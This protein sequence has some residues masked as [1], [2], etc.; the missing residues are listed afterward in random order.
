MK[1]SPFLL[2]YISPFY[3][4]IVWSLFCLALEIMK[5]PQTLII[6]ILE[7][8][9]IPRLIQSCLDLNMVKFVTNHSN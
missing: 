2:P 1:V 4:F 3:S 9:G 5:L 8:I 6:D 7:N